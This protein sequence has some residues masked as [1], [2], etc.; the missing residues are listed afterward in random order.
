LSDF[1]TVWTGL[2][3]V[4]TEVILISMLMQLL[5]I[6]VINFQWRKIA[7]LVGESVPFMEIL[8][9]NMKGTFIETVTPGVKMGGEV[10]RI[11]MFKSQ[12]GFSIGKASAIVGVQ[13]S[14]SL[15][16][17][18]LLNLIALGWFFLKL[19][20]REMMHVGFIG[21]GF[22]FIFAMAGGLVLFLVSPYIIGKVIEKLPLSQKLKDSLKTHLKSFIEALDNV[23]KQKRYLLWQLLLS[24]FIWSFFAF[25]TYYIA[26]AIGIRTDF[27]SMA[28]VTYLT[29]MVAMVPLLPGGIGSFEG[30][31]LFLLLPLG[32]PPQQGMILTLLVRF[33]TFWFVFLLSGLFLFYTGF[34]HRHAELFRTL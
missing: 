12:L 34:I 8:K 19:N 33:V 27:I 6:L 25:K 24:L 22:V 32:I 2:K 20:Q 4:R 5:T 17:F 23:K 11:Y 18:A 29:Y 7:E 10:A 1:K 28:A 9:L 30:S 21:T 13:K 15:T 31:M 16:A 14:V 3:A 26:Y